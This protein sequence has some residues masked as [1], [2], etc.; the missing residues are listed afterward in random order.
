LWSALYDIEGP[1]FFAL[2]LFG[3]KKRRGTI[4]KEEKN[5]KKCVAYPQEDFLF[6]KLITS[7]F[8]LNIGFFI[9]RQ[10][11]KGYIGNAQYGCVEAHF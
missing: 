10:F 2:S 11:N 8:T 7:F 3:R 4:R 6:L 9:Y 5:K 1:F